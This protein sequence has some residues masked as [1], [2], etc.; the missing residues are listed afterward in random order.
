M[1]IEL[2]RLSAPFNA[3]GPDDRLPCI[4]MGDF[5]LTEASPVFAFLSNG[6]LA[7]VNF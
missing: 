5:N 7:Y 2:D 1:F 4:V 3:K 6:F